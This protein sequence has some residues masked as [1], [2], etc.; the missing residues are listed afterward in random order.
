MQRTLT[1]VASCLLIAL[2]SNSSQV[3]ANEGMDNKL[4]ASEQRAKKRFVDDEMM[5]ITLAYSYEQGID[6]TQYWQSEKL[7]GVRAIWD[8]KVLKTRSGRLIYA[9]RWFT[10]PLP[11]YPVE[12]ELWAGRGNFHLVQQTVLDHKPVDKAWEQIDFML[13]DMPHAAG[14]YK[15][16]YYNIVYLVANIDA[17]HINYVA[18]TPISSEHE[19]FDYLDNVD[20]EK[21]EGIMLRKTTSRYQAGRSTDLLKL[22][23]HQD[24]EATIVGYKVGKGKY[25]GM[26]GAVLVEWKPGVRFYIGSGFSDEM[27]RRP[28]PI[29]STITFRHNG[30]TNNHIPKF[31]RYVRMRVE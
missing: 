30:Y 17:K 5:P 14:D 11:D 20:N 3:C 2:A 15:K 16:R 27:R 25:K 10:K 1:A 23:S 19:L 13:F 26:M 22:K 24:D 6:V 28:P 29:G 12:G 31:A 8:G 18:H 7:D 21:G 4:N 9:P